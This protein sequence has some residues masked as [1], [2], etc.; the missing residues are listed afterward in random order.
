[1]KILCNI[2]P[3]W[4]VGGKERALRLV[5]LAAGCG[6]QGVIFELFNVDTLYRKEDDRKRFR[7]FQL[8]N[9]LLPELYSRARNQNL[10]FIIAPFGKEFLRHD[11]DAW[12]VD[13]G[14]ITHVPLL[15]ELSRSKLPIYLGTAGSDMEEIDDA[16]EILRPDAIPDDI[17]IMHDTFGRPTKLDELNLRRLL[18]LG[19]HFLRDLGGEYLSL[20]TGACIHN[21]TTALA[22]MP[23]LYMAEVLEVDF[24]AEDGKG[25]ASSWSF[26]PSGIRQLRVMID[27]LNKARDC[28]CQMTLT[29]EFSRIDKRRSPEDWLRPVQ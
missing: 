23:V 16:I 15:K 5:D 24:D 3:N 17:V 7:P 9:D 8:P 18:E 12:K 11:T 19:E 10:E 1:M 27:S 4:A 6:A 22:A 14:E 25:I 21:N 20:S 2:G 29:D 13:S 28:G 26:T